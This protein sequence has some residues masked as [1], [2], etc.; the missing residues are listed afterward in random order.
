MG[1]GG[2]SRAASL[3][4]P[5]FGDVPNYVEPFAGS[6]AVL[7]ARPH[8]PAIET[9]NDADCVAPATRILFADLTWRTAG[10]V[11]VGDRLIGF[12]EQ[13]GE[14]RE[15]L[16]A[17]KRYRRLAHA[18]VTAVRVLR[19]PSYRLTFDDGTSV[20][21][22]SNHLWLGG[23]HKSGGRGW[24]WVKT[25]NMV[26]NRATQRSWVLKVADVV[27]REESFDAGWLG[28]LIDGEGSLVAGPGLKVTVSQN[29]G[30]VLDR[31]VALLTD[32]GFSG[33]KVGQRKCRQ[34]VPAR[35]MASALRLL[36]RFRPERLIAKLPSRLHEMSLYGRD[37]RAVGLVSKEYLGEQDVVAIE[38]DSHTF[39][40]EGLA[41]HNCYVVNFWRAVTAD[42]DAVAAFADWPV[43]EA[44]QNARH[45]WLV[46]Q[47]G[48]RERM[49]TDPEYFD[50]KVAGW[51]AWGLNVYIGDGWC[52]TRFYRDRQLPH[53]GNAGTG[54]N[55][56][57][58][59]LGDAG[60]GVNRKLPNL[61]TFGG[62]MRSANVGLVEWM[63][64]L[65][66]RLRRVRVCCGDWSRV[67]T[68]SVTTKHGVTAVLLDPPYHS[69]ANQDYAVRGSG[70]VAKDVAAW[71]AEHGDDPLLRIALCG[72][73]GDYDMPDGWV[74][75]H[76]KARKGYQSDDAAA[77][78]ER[79]WFSPH[80]KRPSDQLDFEASA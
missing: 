77:K 46:D 42:P 47:S 30:V 79:I 5:R 56:Q 49:N 36:M 10:S 12:D 13:N 59:H 55:R 50:A 17:P 54:V 31:A 68:P 7:L 64:A 61:T 43:T 28:G 24:R 80:C 51:W 48:F 41:S 38:T 8:A 63:A 65:S 2:K 3:I 62:S 25:E 21:A 19:K 70:D 11:Q 18:T 20:V 34:M 27:E 69:T 45:Q 37:H 32:R 4:W 73:E 67:V 1:F 26:C 71:A 72:Y 16:R 53:L 35:S 74:C 57:L 33:T 23:S 14:A 29:N 9:V 66:D 22:S 58:P 60:K 40:A 39:I 6:L 52:D 15:G 76:G 75:E 44:D 78:K